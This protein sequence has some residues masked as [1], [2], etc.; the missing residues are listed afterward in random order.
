M[1]EQF[2]SEVVNDSDFKFLSVAALLKK[3][4][5]G[6][7][8]EELHREAE[9][10]FDTLIELLSDTYTDNSVSTRFGYSLDEIKEMSLLIFS[11]LISD[12][13]SNPYITLCV[14]ERASIQEI[15]RRRNKLLYIFHP[16]RNR[17]GLINGSITMRINEAYEL[18]ANK[19]CKTD[20]P[21]KYIK[22]RVPSYFA[23]RKKKI[24]ALF[25]IFLIFIFTF[26]MVMKIN[27]FF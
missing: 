20:Q 6:I 2:R 7:G 21:F 16:D 5:N 3:I 22:T 17:D 15:K 23:Y 25:I 8:I 11:R 19:Y 24:F 13:S 27:I 10:K 4:R 1:S 14:S 12:T 18:I 9:R 26:L